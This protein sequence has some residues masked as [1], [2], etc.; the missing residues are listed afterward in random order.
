M[1]IF[2]VRCGAKSAFLPPS[3]GISFS[4]CLICTFFDSLSQLS[5]VKIHREHFQSP[6]EES[7][8]GSVEISV[9]AWLDL[10]TSDASIF[11]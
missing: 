8:A 10:G 7:S 5:L 9:V 3:L 2:S 6:R 1:G 4:N 11:E